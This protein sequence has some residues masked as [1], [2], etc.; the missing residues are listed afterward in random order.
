MVIKKKVYATR[1]RST[2]AKNSFPYDTWM[3]SNSPVLLSSQY[4]DKM[5]ENELH[6]VKDIAA[7]LDWVLHASA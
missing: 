3:Y 5:T 2:W 1:G 6:Y 7:F 4:F